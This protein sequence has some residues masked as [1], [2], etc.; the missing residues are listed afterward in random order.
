MDDASRAWREK[1]LLMQSRISLEH[2]HQYRNE[3]YKVHCLERIK[4]KK[5]RPDQILLPQSDGDSIKSSVSMT[6]VQNIPS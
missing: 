3:M 2:W 6:S 5:I 4:P 1:L